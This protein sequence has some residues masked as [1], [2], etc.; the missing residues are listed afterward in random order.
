[1]VCPHLHGNLG[2][3]TKP[4]CKIDYTILIVTLRSYAVFWETTICVVQWLVNNVLVSPHS[5]H[6]LHLHHRLHKLQMGLQV[7]IRKQSL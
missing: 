2:S 5:H 7:R 3:V 1:M 4:V 6:L